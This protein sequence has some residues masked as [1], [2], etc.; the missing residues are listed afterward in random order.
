MAEAAWQVG[1]A[2][3]GWPTQVREFAAGAGGVTERFAAD[4]LALREPFDHAAR[5]VALARRLADRLPSAAAAGGSR[6]R[7][8]QHVPFPRADHRARSGLDPGRCRCRAAGRGVRPH[9][10]VGTATRASPRRRRA[11]SCSVS[12]PHGLWRM[13]AVQRDLRPTVIAGVGGPIGLPASRKD[14]DGRAKPGHDD[15]DAVVCSALLDLVSA[16]WLARLCDTLHGAVPRLPHR[17]WPRC[18]AAAPSKRC[19]GAHRLPARHA[20]RQRLRPRTWN[21]AHRRVACM[22]RAAARPHRRRATGGFRAPRSAC[23]VR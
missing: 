23:S 7:H 9:R 21:C 20:A 6:R 15:V 14:V 18:L 13:R 17:R 5:S 3:P 12:T 19:T 10:R 8:R 22:P 11:M 16:A 1:Q 2:L 4:W